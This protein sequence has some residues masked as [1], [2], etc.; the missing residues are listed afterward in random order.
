MAKFV[1]KF[2]VLHGNLCMDINVNNVFT[3]IFIYLFLL[4][5]LKKAAVV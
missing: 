5:R 4:R 2:Q 1:Q 3:F